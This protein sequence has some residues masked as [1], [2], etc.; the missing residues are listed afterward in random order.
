[1]EI[2]DIFDQNNKNNTAVLSSINNDNTLKC[3]PQYIP[4][5]IARSISNKGK[6]A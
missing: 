3:R 6:Y 4:K 5:I 2:F 1:L